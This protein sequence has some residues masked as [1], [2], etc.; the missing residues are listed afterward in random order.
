ML[1]GVQNAFFT[2]A[3]PG[4]FMDLPPWFLSRGYVNYMA[5]SF[6]VERNR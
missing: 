6:G 3:Y 4:G 1:F 5:F 2:K